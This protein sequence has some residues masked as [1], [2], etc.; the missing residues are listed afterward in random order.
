MNDNTFGTYQLPNTAC[1]PQNHLRDYFAPDITWTVSKNVCH[2]LNPMSYVEA[3][4]KIQYNVNFTKLP[5]FTFTSQVMNNFYKAYITIQYAD[6]IYENNRFIKQLSTSCLAYDRL[7]LQGEH[8]YLW[9]T[10]SDNE[11]LALLPPDS[12]NSFRSKDW[13]R[14]EK[15]LELRFMLI[16]S[17]KQTCGNIMRTSPN[18]PTELIRPLWGGKVQQYHCFIDKQEISISPQI[19]WLLLIQDEHY[20]YRLIGLDD[21][22]KYFTTDYIDLPRIKSIFF[23]HDQKK[24]ILSPDSFSCQ[25]NDYKQIRKIINFFNGRGLA[26]PPEQSTTKIIRVSHDS[27]LERTPSISPTSE[28]Y[29]LLKDTLAIPPLEKQLFSSEELTS[30]FSIP[31]NQNLAPL[32]DALALDWCGRY[33][34]ALAALES[35]DTPEARLE[36]GIF[37]KAGRPGLVPDSARGNTILEKLIEEFEEREGNLNGHECLIAG[38]ACMERRPQRGD[39]HYPHWHELGEDYFQRALNLGVKDA[40]F[41]LYYYK[42]AMLDA[43]FWPPWETDNLEVLS[44]LAATPGYRSNLWQFRRRDEH[45]EILRQ[46]IFKRCR[47]AQYYLGLLYLRCGAYLKIDHGRAHFWLQRAADRGI[48][49]AWIELVSPQLQS[50]PP[51]SI[52]P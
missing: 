13:I 30:L 20:K 5:N 17:E 33:H 4:G 14:A 19:Q 44:A 32:D 34:K 42:P 35:I 31:K 23:D 1:Y 8:S 16:S 11:I 46:A 26:I 10:L 38:R 37:L 49:P 27:S 15:P 47:L 22:L 28:E 45:L 39:K 18:L 12:S 3:M 9:C 50:V 52:K 2:F 21:N 43:S 48:Q 51:D 6:N 7:H 24:I 29:Q 40:R 36:L 25:P 41:Y